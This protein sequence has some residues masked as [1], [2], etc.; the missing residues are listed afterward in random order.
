MSASPPSARP[1]V[2]IVG[3]YPPPYG[4]ISVG[5][6]R[7][8]RRLDDARIDYTIYNESAQPSSGP[9]VRSA[10][11]PRRL[12]LDLLLRGPRRILH[13]QSPDWRMR[14]LVSLWG[15]LTGRKSVISIHGASFDFSMRSSGLQRALIKFFTARTSAVI[16]CNP[17]IQS[18]V[19]ALT[20]RPERVHMVPAFILPP[21]S[22]AEAPL[23][24][25]LN[26]FLS[27]HHP[28]LLWVGW[29]EP[30][31]GRDLYGLDLT[32]D[33]IER[34]RGRFPEI[35]CVLWFSGIRDEPLWMELWASVVRRGMEKHFQIE[36]SALPEIYPLFRHAD[37]YL[38]PTLTD[39]DSVS[40]RE[41]L[42]LG[43]P[44]VASDAAPRSPACVTFKKGDAEAFTRAV[45]GV[46]TDLESARAHARSEVQE[47][48]GA[49]IFAIYRE[50][51]L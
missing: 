47:D 2:G 39:G 45:D 31:E 22:A 48:N 49:K 9:R 30:F 15:M 23:P 3:P 1:A 33:L 50:L 34:L 6:Q 37:V 11:G 27:G 42:S 38:R 12:F 20:G 7:L 46:L 21:R 24:A 8:A 5:I 43:T 26:G 18:Q 10:P 13:Y 29:V 44:V 25:G 40:V 16:A 51:G 4:G 32:F 28:K 17:E 41:A 36:R 35:G 14:C 19:A